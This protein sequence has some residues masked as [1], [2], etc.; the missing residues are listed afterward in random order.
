[1]RRIAVALISVLAG[2]AV[3]ASSG[4]ADVLLD[5]V[6]LVAASGVAPPSE[7]PFTLATAQPLTVTL[8]DFQT[9][10]AFTSLQLA[11][12]LGD[13]LVGTST[14]VDAASSTATVAVPGV[15]GDYVL[16]VIGTPAAGQGFGSFGVCVAPAASPTQCI[17]ADS[18]AGNIETPSSASTTATSTLNTNFTSTVAGN[19]TVTLTDD[20]FPVALQTLSAGIFQGSTPVGVAI[21]EG[22]TQVTLAAGTSYQLLVAA[23]ALCRW[24]R[25]RHRRW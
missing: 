10:A 2:M 14:V 11:V 23:T 25:C 4:R 22:G 24:A 8:T 17:A 7:F 13:T 15:A 9:P 1:M 16:H 21:P 20:A 6:N 3:F 5:Q 19:Y 18:F 12:T